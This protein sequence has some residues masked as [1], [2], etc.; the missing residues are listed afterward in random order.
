MVPQACWAGEAQESQSRHVASS[1]HLS[2]C[3]GGQDALQQGLVGEEQRE[4]RASL[5][6]STAWG[7]PPELARPVREEW[8]HHLL[9]P[10][11]ELCCNS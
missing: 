9:P 7:S 4:R 1:A 11:A 6:P 2:V 8:P 10:P 3:V 5:W